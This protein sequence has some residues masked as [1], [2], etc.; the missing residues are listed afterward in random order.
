MP[1]YKIF[2]IDNI[3][4]RS[5][6]EARRLIQQGGAKLNGKKFLTVIT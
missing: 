5:N 6:S 3:L 1:L 2:T 4:C